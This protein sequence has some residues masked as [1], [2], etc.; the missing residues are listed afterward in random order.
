MLQR[1]LAFLALGAV[2]LAAMGCGG[3]RNP[4]V[5][6]SAKKI[7]SQESKSFKSE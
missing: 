2:L 4:S 5:K 1:V 6:G 7:D 3:D